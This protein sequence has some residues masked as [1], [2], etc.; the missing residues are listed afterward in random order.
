M[1]MKIGLCGFVVELAMGSSFR[2]PS[3]REPKK[4]VNWRVIELAEI[5]FASY[6]AA[7]PVSVTKMPLI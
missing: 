1:S 5:A 2:C 3:V 4:V 6:V 7:D